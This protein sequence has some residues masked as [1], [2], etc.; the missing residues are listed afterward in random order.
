MIL[1]LIVA[2]CLLT[3]VLA[4]C[5]LGPA[6][7][8]VT[9]GPVGTAIALPAP[10][11]ATRLATPLPQGAG[12]ATPTRSSAG[13][14]FRATPVFSPVARTYLDHALDWIQQNSIRKNEMD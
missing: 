11:T 9:T 14:E 7:P 13:P 1:R 2:F 8:T 5:D 6:S 10:V 4:A 12:V 3:L